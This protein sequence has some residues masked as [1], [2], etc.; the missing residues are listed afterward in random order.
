MGNTVPNPTAKLSYLYESFNDIVIQNMYSSMAI[1][2]CEVTAFQNQK[3]I[4][5]D[6]SLN[7]CSLNINQYANVL[8]NLMAFFSQTFNNSSDETGQ[9]LAFIS[10]TV[11]SFTSSPD[12]VIAQFKDIAD[13]TMK[14]RSIDMD[15]NTYLKNSIY[16]NINVQDF[17]SCRSNV[18]VVQDQDIQIN[19]S[20]CVNGKI[21]IDQTA[22]VQ[23]YAKCIMGGLMNA[24]S[25][26]PSFR[27]ILRN[28]NNDISG[29][30]D[31]V[32]GEI[33]S[34]C[35]NRDGSP[36]SAEPDVDPNIKLI[37]N[38]VS[39]FGI[40]FFLAILIIFIVFI[41]KKE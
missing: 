35:F 20:K 32:F 6:V 16:K 7:N 36:I 23:D 15:I 34:I 2:E 12:P 37:A 19:Q 4:I 41:I 25:A 33:P 39:V 31:Q 14:N 22:V 11:E 24:I 38:A 29:A 30:P 18:F 3:I 28:F 5:S 17:K 8:C 13:K 26:E 9:I 1:A 21:E 27:D 10:K 40:F